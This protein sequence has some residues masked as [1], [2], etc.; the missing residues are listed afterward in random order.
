MAFSD[1]QKTLIEILSVIRSVL[2]ELVNFRITEDQL[3]FQSAWLNEVRPRLDQLISEVQSTSGE[4][5]PY[6]RALQDRGLTGESLRLKRARLAAVSRKGILKKILDIINTILGSIPGA[7][8]IK[9]F[10]ELAE[11]AVD[12][13]NAS[14]SQNFF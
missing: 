7:D 6:W 11:E 8:P 10:K 5:N 14:V 13:P 2:E 4:A 1:D 3:L 12:D 9:E